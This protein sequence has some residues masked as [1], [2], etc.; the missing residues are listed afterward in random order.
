MFFFNGTP[1]TEIYTYRHTLSLHDAPPISER[2]QVP[3][4]SLIE[5]NAL[6]PPYR[7]APGTEL[8]IPVQNQH[9]VQAGETVYGISRQYGVD[10]STLIK[11]NGLPAP[12][13]VEPGPVLLLPAPVETQAVAGEVTNEE[14]GRAPV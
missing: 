1:T 12:Y 6:Q 4:R 7:L 13:S 3:I 10:A 14:L 11:L 2:F 5:L 9:R 8:R